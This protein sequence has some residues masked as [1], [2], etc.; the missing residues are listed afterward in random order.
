ML[1]RTVW[2]LGLVS[3]LNDAASEM[4]FPL[5][6]LFLTSVLGAGAAVLGLIE[7]LAEAASSILKLLSGRA[8]DRGASSRR[9]V[10]AGYAAA[11]LARPLIGLADA[12]FWVLGLRLLD[13]AGKG[14]R[15]S[16]RD[17]MLSTSVPGSLRGR[18]FGL[19]RSMDHAGAMIGP[20][21]A[22]ALLGL[23]LDLR[24]VF[25]ASIVPG[26][27]LLFLLLRG[28]PAT[29]ARVRSP[30]PLRWRLLPGGLRAL[31]VAAAGLA[32]A[33]VPEAFVIL[34]A[35]RGGTAMTIVPL[36][37]AAAHAVRM[38]AA[39]PAGMLSDQ[40]GR[41]AVL[42]LS[43]GGRVGLVSVMA[44]W[45][46]RGAWIALVFV[47]Y[48]MVTA[49]S[50][51]AERALIGDVAAADT[52]ATAFGLYHLCAGL[53]ALPGALVFGLIWQHVSMAAA[54]LFSAALTAVSAAALLRMLR[55]ESAA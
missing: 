8:A 20:L 19:H 37:W 52:K 13:R 30:A 1:P 11:N 49:M 3:L 22:F 36:L 21:L 9:M 14:W 46:L 55:R 44:L 17:A 25:L 32:F 45:P 42:L 41:P 2:L 40:I 34:W 15:T 29:P 5:L 24:Q 54:M 27:L 53:A 31:I 18:A 16:P 28:L 38:L 10:I 51:A 33:A 48:A 6:P 12:W 23:G 26:I 47:L 7:G 4:I 35:W 39:A 43:W 50:E